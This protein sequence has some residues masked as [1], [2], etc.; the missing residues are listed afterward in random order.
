ME[1]YQNW[2]YTVLTKNKSK[3]KNMKKY[4]RE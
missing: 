4:Q 1:Q 3:A 2:E